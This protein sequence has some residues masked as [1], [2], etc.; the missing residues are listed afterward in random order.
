MPSLYFRNGQAQWNNPVQVLLRTSVP[1]LSLAATVRKE[2]RNWNQRLLIGKVES[3]DNMLA[4]SVAVP[5]FYMML[6][7]GFAALALV[8]SAVG[9]YGTINYSVARRTHEIGIRM[10][11]GADRENVLAMIFKQGLSLVTAGLVL[12]ISGAWMA[13][14]VLRTL[15]FGVQPTDG[16]AFAGGVGVLILSVLLA[17]YVPARRATR[18]DPLEALRHQ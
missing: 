11:L 15:L 12:G 7:T 10:A 13:T 14:R 2:V 8:V 4:E 3:M 6:I 18:V 16:M 9:I 17:C 5:R 1:P